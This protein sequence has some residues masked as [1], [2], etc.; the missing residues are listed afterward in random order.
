MPP[1]EQ[2]H[3]LVDRL[4]DSEIQTALKLLTA[5]NMDPLTL[6]LLNAPDDDEPY[7]EQ[8][9]R[10]DAE[11][12]AAIDRGEFIFLDDLKRELGL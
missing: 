9:Q 11:A 10:E 8:Q 1:K 3:Q 7:T 4:P 12:D 5:L 6:L 2:L